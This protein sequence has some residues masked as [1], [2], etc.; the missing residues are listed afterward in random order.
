MNNTPDEIYLGSVEKWK[1]NKGVGMIV[2]TEYLDLFIPLFHILEKILNKNNNA[3]ILVILSNTNYLDI[4]TTKIVSSKIFTHF[5]V[6]N[7]NVKIVVKEDYE[8]IDRSEKYDLL[9]L[10]RA[11]DIILSEYAN[12]IYD[13]DFKHIL[14][15]S[16][17]KLLNTKTSIPIIDS[18]SK[19][20]ILFK[21]ISSDS[22]EYNLGIDMDEKDTIKYSEINTF[23]GDTM[24]MFNNDIDMVFKCYSGG[25]EGGIN[26]SGDY[27]RQKVAENAG[28]NK[29]LDL[30]LEYYANIDRYYNP[31]AIYERA[32]TF[33]MMING[34]KQLLSDNHVKI[35]PIIDIIKSN[36][37][38]KIVIIS[39]RS[40][41]A[42]AITKE[43]N[44]HIKYTEDVNVFNYKVVKDDCVKPNT[45]IDFNSDLETITVMT[46]SGD[47]IRSKNGSIKKFGSTLQNKAAN[48]L[49]NSGKV[50]VLSCNDALPESANFTTDL[51]IYTSP[52]CKS[53]SELRYRIAGLKFTNEEIVLNLFLNNTKEMETLFNKQSVTKKNIQNIKNILEIV[54]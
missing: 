30:S 16:N 32:K 33:N 17:D 47:Y 52:E 42:L 1:N 10:L 19:V 2:Y 43:I 34:R 18:I 11:E 29:E 48:E 49:F 9:V 4:F 6:L 5:N 7:I 15:L 53:I 14:L 50:N 20:D 13:I 54:W 44:K 35:Q 46:S 38:K 26:Y 51:F 25:K 40:D 3:N 27:F 24:K 23:I 28:W 45:C 39:K 36:P 22:T 12:F 8:L 41:F 21:N 37:T 31:N